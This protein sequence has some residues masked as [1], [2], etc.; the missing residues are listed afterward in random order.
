MACCIYT[1]NKSLGKP[2]LF[3]EKS[4]QI[5]CN[6]K[7][8]QHFTANAI[9]MHTDIGSYIRL[10][11]SSNRPLVEPMLNKIWGNLSVTR[12]Q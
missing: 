12:P 2:L 9:D 4:F 3:Q 5:H 11:P 1:S 10:V 6:D 8:Q 7:Y